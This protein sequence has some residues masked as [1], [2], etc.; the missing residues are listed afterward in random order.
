M[1]IGW[2][3]C[4]SSYF[5]WLYERQNY[6]ESDLFGSTQVESPI[7]RARSQIC[8][9]YKLG[10]RFVRACHL[11]LTQQCIALS[12]FCWSLLT[13]FNI[14]RQHEDQFSTSVRNNQKRM[15]L[16]Y[17]YLTKH[18]REG[19]KNNWLLSGHVR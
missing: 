9:Q 15:F 19:V 4:L 14:F 5:I 12:V 1:K 7:C 2:K 18:I 16:Y 10:V 11:A 17:M 8:T 3:K 13:Q 6:L